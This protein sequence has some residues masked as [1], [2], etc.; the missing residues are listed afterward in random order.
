[1]VA[2]RQ[3]QPTYR[4]A[5]LV[6]LVAIVGPT[7]VL[8]YL[9][10]Q[11][12]QRQGEAI[13]SLTVSNLRLSG[14]RLA[15]EVER[16]SQALA[17]SCLRDDELS[18]LKLAAGGPKTL[19]EAREAR[20]VFERMKARHPMA[21]HFFVLQGNAVRYPLLRTPPP[22]PLDVYSAHE[23]P[24]VRERFAALF[25][26]AEDLEL[27]RERPGQALST[28]RQC[29]QPQVSD[30]LKALALLRV[31]RCLRKLNRLTGAEESY[32]TLR[33]KYGD[34]YD[35]FHRPYGIVASLE[36]LELKKKRGQPTR[37]MLTRSYRDLTR[38]R[39]ELSAEQ[40]DYF[41]ARLGEHLEEPLAE[42]KESEYVSHFEVAR[43]LQEGFRLHG[44]LREG[45]VYAYAFSRGQGSYQSYYTVIPN[46]V[47]KE[48]VVG[49]AVDLNWVEHHL[50]PQ[51]T[52]EMGMGTNVGLRWKST[53]GPTREAN[54]SEVRVG[55]GTLYPFWE[56]NVPV[57]S[58][59]SR[60]VAARHDMLIYAGSTLLILCVLV[61]GV[62]LLIRDVSREHRLTQLRADFVSS[63]SHEL[64][65]P[66][67]LIRLY[68]ETLSYGSDA[69]EEERRTYYQIITRESERL[70][71]LIEKVL[72]FSRI[73]RGQKEYHMQEGD[74]AP[75]VGRAVEV[76]GQYLRRR[77][78]SVK[79]DLQADVANVLFDPDAV[80]EAL[81]N[82]M[83]NAAKY[84]GDSKA[85][86]VRLRS[87]DDEVILEVEDRGIG[88]PAS[89]REKIFQRFYQGRAGAE[90]GSYGLGLFIVKHIMDAH[91]GRV[92]CE[93]GNECGSVFRLIFPVR[94]SSMGAAGSQ[95]S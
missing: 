54:S 5:I 74:L 26:E 30:S 9:G 36:L 46:G 49:F 16:Q 64:K 40:M 3:T 72:D 47:R 86:A 1:M 34:L 41:L 18:E 81:L 61:L 4:R 24:A 94:T 29:L 21:R 59:E 11:S 84:S 19:Q 39:W 56:L 28:Y 92:V 88:I 25:A 68:A 52:A 38:G 70:S 51:C 77:G 79:A 15:A 14:E 2:P 82:L 80:S 32:G 7:L 22:Q 58:D 8:L 53:E 93:S 31:A 10:M 85:V 12:V 66:L 43:A 89:E 67:T 95:A 57:R 35:P 73:E 6:Y 48:A 33:E 78:F 90:K 91:G 27:R 75:V 69:P 63:V 42:P 50:L 20:R 76:Y 17:E 13:N 60:Q 45:E 71:H 62:F 83:D 87:Q 44:S 55:F 65:T 23:D 37:Q